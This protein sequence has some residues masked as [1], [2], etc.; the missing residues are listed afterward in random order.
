VVIA[1]AIGLLLGQSL[2]AW[3]RCG[4]AEA[5]VA[6]TAAVA[7]TLLRH[8][9][10]ASVLQCLAAVLVGLW[11]ASRV[12]EPPDDC[13]VP[14]LAGVTKRWIEVD[15]VEAPSFVRDG[16]RLRAEA[17]LP[18]YDP[19]RICGYILLTIADPSGDFGVG[20]RLRL[21][22]SLRRPRDFAN[23]RTYAYAEGLARR[24]V[25]TTGYS[26][27]RGITR[28]GSV[29]RASRL[30]RERQRIGRIIAASLPPREA[31]LMRALVVGDQASVAAED[32]N[33]ITAAGLAHLVSVSG[34]HIALVWGIV[35][36]AARWVLS[37]SE[38]LLLHADVRALAG[39]AALP[40]AMTYAALAGLSVPAAR[41]VAMTAL[42]VSSLVVGREV[43]PLR[44][45]ALAAGGIALVSPGAVLGVSFQ[46]SFASV[47]ALIVV[48]Q[49][50]STRPRP[51]APP[52][53]ARRVVGAAALAI[54]VSAAALVGTSP[55]VAF[56]FNRLT[57][58]G[59]LT[60]PI[61]VPIAGTPATMLGV[62]GAVASLV[63]EPC[64]RIAFGL[65][66]W[67]L[68]L[69]REGALA[70]A[71]L[72]MASIRVPTPTL[73][74][75]TIAYVLLALPWIAPRRRR[76]VAAVVLGALAL[77]GAWWV[78]ERWL[79]SRLRV[80]FLDVGQGDAAVLELPGGEIV[81]IDGGGFGRSGF[82]VGERVVAPYLWSR[83]IRRID[84]LVATHGD[85]DHQGGLHFLAREFAPRELWM[86]A[87]A[88]EQERL[89]ALTDSVRTSGGRVRL[90]HAGEAVY[91]RSGV[92]IE[93]L[94]P[95]DA[96]AVS[97]NDS[98]LVLRLGFGRHLLLFTGDV[99]A[100]GEA[101]VTTRFAPRPV[102]IL[103]VPHHGSGTSSSPSLLRWA[104]PEVAVF[105][106]G[107]GNSYG[108]PQPAVIERYRSAGTRTLRTDRDGSV[109]V[110]TDGE[111]Y[112]VRAT[113]EASPALCA[114]AGVLC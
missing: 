77:D 113:T 97:G 103:K 107:A 16:I 51:I 92:T 3:L 48:G 49:E 2:S 114:I 60:N 59:L 91:A 46:L 33:A 41:S 109:W 99:E 67:P 43:R 9:A 104:R 79:D 82:D 10:A 17:R 23:P 74:E 19:E 57:P 96:A 45:L 86:S 38:W 50:W 28:L 61:L 83:K 64:A 85:W 1:L 101:A 53:L 11:L 106:L 108:F 56:H 65:A 102:S 76:V 89:A 112:E 31:G 36:A 39:L 6:T 34:L 42:G 110:S 8:S 22:A 25:W 35:F 70:A 75:L 78:R 27:G 93:C 105:S 66:F 55:L 111:R 72:P 37:R 40:T 95:P 62:A 15:V 88:M 98:S 63:S 26:S 24:G 71:A 73:A 58:I 81:V 12:V 52:A 94:H 100:A 47:L 29:P 21:H 32:W 44:V 4:A 30:E 90:V 87:S 7:S 84:V 14:S 18:G 5:L 20:E 80:R 68:A 69:L 54:L 13:F